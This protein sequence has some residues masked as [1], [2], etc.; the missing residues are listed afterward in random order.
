[1]PQAAGLLHLKSP[2]SFLFRGCKPKL[3]K[4][5]RQDR[6]TLT[7]AFCGCSPCGY[8]VFDGQ[9]QVDDFATAAVCA[10]AAF[11]VADAFADARDDYAS[12][13]AVADFG[14][15]QAVAAV[16]F[17]FEAAVVAVFVTGDCSF[18]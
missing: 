6:Q 14:F 13:A 16:H 8:A 2:K 5:F 18:G 11:V 4:A 1:M 7:F 9:V 15:E 10:D 3:A 12:V 17:A